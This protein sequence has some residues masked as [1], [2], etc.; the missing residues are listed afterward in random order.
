[1]VPT[2]RSCTTTNQAALRPDGAHR[3]RLLD[4]GWLVAP[5][6]MADGRPTE[7]MMT[8]EQAGELLGL[9]AGTVRRWRARRF[10]EPP[11]F[12]DGSHAIPIA[13]VPAEQEAQRSRRLLS[14]VV[15]ELHLDYQE[16]YNRIKAHGWPLTCDDD[17]RP[18][19]P[20]ET[21][22]HLLDYLAGQE[23]LHARAVPLLVAARMLG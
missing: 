22:A 3:C 16:T 5:T 17:R 15:S 18:V 14:D 9:K 23:A 11:R 21:E 12:E 19:V 10:P 4:C 2:V 1:M 20:E 7:A 6:A 13:A 8:C